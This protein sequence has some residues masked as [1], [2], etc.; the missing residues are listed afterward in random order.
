MIDPTEVINVFISKILVLLEIK[1]DNLPSPERRSILISGIVKYYGNHT[2]EE[3]YLACEM[4]FFGKF[5]TRIDHFGKFSIDYLSN[6]LHLF[7]EEKK[8]EVLKQ[9]RKE[10][11]TLIP[12]NSTN[13]SHFQYIKKFYEE[14]KTFP[15][16]NYSRA[17]DHLLDTKQVDI[18][19]LKAFYENEKIKIIAE[20]KAKNAYATSQIERRAFEIMLQ[21]PNIKL[22]C[23][24]RYVQ[25]FLNS[26]KTAL[27]DAS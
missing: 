7:A 9:K 14:N 21:E 6:C 10:S 3:L 2:V 20:I 8:A 19:G 23:R 5:T 24:K 18:E 15:A 4:N 27:D 1:S 17:F 13:E 22:E 12:D 25:K 16:A 11:P 26:L